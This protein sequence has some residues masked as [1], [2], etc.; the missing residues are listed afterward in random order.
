MRGRSMRKHMW[1]GDRGGEKMEEIKK[2]RCVGWGGIDLGSVV[3]SHT[4]MFLRHNGVMIGW[5]KC[6]FKAGT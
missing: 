5:G 4:R 6:G 3:W 2:E 1:D